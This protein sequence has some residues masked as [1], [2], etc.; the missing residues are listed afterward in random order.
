MIYII[1]AV[2]MILVMVNYF[3]RLEAQSKET[4]Q[5]LKSILE[6]LKNSKK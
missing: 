4:N 1:I 2:I 6:E 3:V 5:I